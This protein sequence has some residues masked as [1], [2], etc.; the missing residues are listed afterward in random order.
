MKQLKLFALVVAVSVLQ[1]CLA[2]TM[3]RH[4]MGAGSGNFE[5]AIMHVS[6]TIGQSEP[7]NTVVQPTV[8]L[9]SGFQQ[10]DAV[11]VSVPEADLVGNIMLYPNP[12]KDHV[13]INLTLE[14]PTALNYTIYDV[15][16]RVLLNGSTESLQGEY[17]KKVDLSNLPPGM[18]YLKLEAWRQE[19]P[20]YHSFKIIKQ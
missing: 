3:P 7:V 6:W 14:D 16:A 13:M 17:S 11:P 5:S 12:C 1:P 2:Q 10:N 4:A 9:C 19:G 8:I 20:E 18:Y 15:S